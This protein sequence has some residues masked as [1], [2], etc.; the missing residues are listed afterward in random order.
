MP[1]LTKTTTSV[2]A[3]PVSGLRI[4]ALDATCRGKDVKSSLLPVASSTDWHVKPGEKSEIDETKE[5]TTLILNVL[6][7]G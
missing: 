5:L 3:E 1:E 2:Q 7:R 4:L 6:Q